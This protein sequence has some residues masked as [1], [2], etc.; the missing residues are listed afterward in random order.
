[1]GDVEE[2]RVV[3]SPVEG[4]N[5]LGAVLPRHCDRLA[6]VKLRRVVKD[7][8]YPNSENY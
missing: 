5:R 8:S 3:F 4:T 1:V 6:Q 7:A 2:L